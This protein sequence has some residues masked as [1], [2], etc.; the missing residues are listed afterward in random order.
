MI[1]DGQVGLLNLIGL[2]ARIDMIF[3]PMII[4]SELL[5]VLLES[6][7]LIGG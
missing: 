6:V 4:S 5:F 1:V 2:F 7:L 3:M